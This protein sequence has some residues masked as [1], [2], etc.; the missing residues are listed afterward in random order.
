[1]NFLLEFSLNFN[2]IFLLMLKKILL[3][4]FLFASFFSVW[5]ADECFQ[6]DCSWENVQIET[7]QEESDWEGGNCPSGTLCSPDFMIK[8][9]DIS[10]GAKFVSDN[11]WSESSKKAL[12]V[13]LW[14]VIQKLMIAFWVLALLIM[15][16]WGWFMIFYHGQDELLSK[17]KTI[18][19]AGI[20]ALFI[21]LGSYFLVSLVRYILYA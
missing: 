17:W 18:F 12:N 10:P 11:W 4:L 14:T 8:V 9:S 19:S 7:V 16:I 6:W 5:S 13:L 1:M 15:T 20:I 21:A 2:S 3:G